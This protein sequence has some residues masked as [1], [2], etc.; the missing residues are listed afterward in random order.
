MSEETLG[1]AIVPPKD[2]T[3]ESAP[4]SVSVCHSFQ[5][6][7]Q[8]RFDK[9]NTLLSFFSANSRGLG[10]KLRGAQGT[11]AQEATV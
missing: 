10:G 6:G 8:N 11:F 4:I 9:N 1:C 5:C 7:L 2:P 3:I